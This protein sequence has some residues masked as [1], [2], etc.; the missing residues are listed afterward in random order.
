MKKISRIYLN[1]RGRPAAIL[2]PS[3]MLMLS[4]VCLAGL[5]VLGSC[6]TGSENHCMGGIETPCIPPDEPFGQLSDYGLFNG[7]ISDLEPV[8][9]L[10]PFDLNTP[11]FSDYAVKLRMVY[12][13][14]DSSAVY[15]E[16][17]VL[18]F[19]IGSVLVKN[20]FYENDR[21]NPTAGRQLIE[22]RLLMRQQQGWRAETYEWN[23]QQTEA[24]LQQV[25]AS[26][27]VAWVDRDGI[28]RKANYLIPAKNDC[29]TCHEENSAL[30]PLGPKVRNLNKE[31]S[32]ADGEQHQLVRWKQE[33]ILQ[34]L[35]DLPVVP[36]VPVWDDSST[37]TLNERARIY[38]D[39][40]C[41][42]CHNPAGFGSYTALFLNLEEERERNLGIYKMPVAFGYGDLKYDIVPGQPDSSIMVLRMESVETEIRMPELGRTL[43]HEEG[44]A[45]I[46]EWI[47]NLECASCE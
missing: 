37:G 13:P 8:E 4:M 35:P 19:P 22:T 18:E 6:G 33:G 7:N 12:V 32:Y 11:L 5:F 25:G 3:G 15:N 36:K 43:V 21:R 16:T 46:R 28:Q 20:F 30:V 44:V 2:T 47:E 10:I 1:S 38:L 34:G 23:E 41:G 31:Y 14:V 27:E 42:N 26:K 9:G 17:S 29:K 39:V 40:N 45:L 24:V